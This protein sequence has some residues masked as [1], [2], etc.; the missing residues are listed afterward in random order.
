MRDLHIPAYRDRS[1]AACLRRL[2][3]RIRSRITRFERCSRF[4]VRRDADGIDYITP[5]PNGAVPMA[6]RRAR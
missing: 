3:E 4:S 6:A 1:L 5:T 2:G